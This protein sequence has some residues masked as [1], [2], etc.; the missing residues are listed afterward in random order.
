VNGSFK[1]IPNLLTALR[2]AAAPALAILLVAGD[3]GAALGIF[4]FAGLSDAADGFLAK[5]YGMT[6]RFGRYLDP[7]ADKLLML[8]AFL[9]LAFLGLSPWWLTV[10]VIARDVAIVLAVLVAY[11]L[12]LP[13]RV[14]PLFIG[15]VNT[16]VQVSY[17]GLI[18][19]F[20]VFGADAP[21]ISGWAVLVTATFT[22]VSWFAYAG[23]WFGALFAR[24]RIA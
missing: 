19:I 23:L 22:I 18:L 3:Y 17:I 12:A 1:H 8:A 13:L 4:A 7:A 24:N 5:R 21:Q 14:Q 9:T 15:K 2:L 10:L 11:M 16:V 6:T 20:L